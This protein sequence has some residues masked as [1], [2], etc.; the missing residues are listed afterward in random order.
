MPP[1]AA[2]SRPNKSVTVA[3]RV[4]TK[5]LAEIERLA[6]AGG[7]HSADRPAGKLRGYVVLCRAATAQDE[8]LAVALAAIGQ[9]LTVY[10][11]L[12]PPNQGVTPYT[13]IY[14]LYPTNGLVPSG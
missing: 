8:M 6:A 3:T 13:Q 9:G 5:D 12:D 2:S 10:A 11:V 14:E 4:S 1:G 7:A